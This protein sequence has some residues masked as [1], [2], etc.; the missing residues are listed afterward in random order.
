MTKFNPTSPVGFLMLVLET[1]TRHAR[2]QERGASAVEWVV[3][4]AILVTVVIAVG[5]L[6]TTALRGKAQDVSN[7]IQS[8]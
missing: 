3:I 5:L 6:L 8:G 4:S 2:Q 7:D 1:R